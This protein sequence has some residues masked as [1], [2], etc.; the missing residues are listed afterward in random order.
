[1]RRIEDVEGLALAVH[2]PVVRLAEC[3]A[4]GVAG[5]SAAPNA[6]LA[7]HVEAV[8]FHSAAAVDAADAHQLV[9]NCTASLRFWEHA[10]QLLL[11]WTWRLPARSHGTKRDLSR[12]RCLGRM[13]RHLIHVGQLRKL[14]GDDHVRHDNRR[15]RR[16]SGRS[17]KARWP[18][19]RR[20]QRL[21][22]VAAVEEDPCGVG[23]ASA[24]QLGALGVARALG[25]GTGSPG[26]GHRD[27]R[28]GRCGS[29][30]HVLF[31]LLLLA[32]RNL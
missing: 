22:A 10:L 30:N 13:L 26:L 12:P 15:H 27:G 11:G 3:V 1:M 16:R 21:E 2:E 23:A 6:G 29:K 20:W 25:A 8:I 17:L 9:S 28:H 7:P 14:L 19:W 4:G 5:P 32:G 31:R 24:L 18:R